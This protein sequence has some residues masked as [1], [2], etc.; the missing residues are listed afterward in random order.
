MYL[1]SDVVFFFLRDDERLTPLILAA[2]CGCPFT[3]SV[4]LD[5]GAKIDATDKN[6]VR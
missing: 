5:R 2:S 1:Q 4:L 6:G 3:S